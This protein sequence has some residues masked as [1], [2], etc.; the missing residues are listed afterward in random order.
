MN[1]AQR[2][3][4][5]L[6]SIQ[7]PVL[8]FSGG[9]IARN[10]PANP[11][12]FRAD[13]TFHYFFAK[14]EAGS[15]AWFD[16]AN[17]T[18]TLFL[19]ERTVADALWH[20]T[21]ES[22][23]AAK[24]RHEV[25]EVLPV[26]E[27]EAQVARLAGG[28]QVRSLAVA[29]AK[30]TARARAITG[31]ALLFDDDTQAVDPQL[32]QVIAAQRLIKSDEEVEEQRRLVPVTREAH[33]LAMRHSRPGVAEQVLA[34]HVEGAFARAGC[35]PA[36]GTILSVRGEVLHNHGHHHVLANG[37]IV[38]LDAGPESMETGYCNDVTRC[39]P[40]GGFSPE[41]RDVYQ[42]VLDAQLAAIAAVKPGARFRDLHLLAARVLAQGLVSM[43]LLNGTV[44]GLVETGAH[45]MFF[46]HGL[47]H[48]LGLDV[49]DLETFGDQI[50]YPNGRTRSPQFGTQYLRMDMDLAAGMTFTIEPGLYFVPAILHNAEFRARFGDQVRWNRAE[51]FLSM[52]GGRG[53]GG[54]RIED[55]VLCT[56]S[57]SE[58]LTAAIPKSVKE[59]EALAGAL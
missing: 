36:Y 25:T 24:A 2:R 4:R 50:H 3:A 16:P 21:L 26:G 37:D 12:P 43:G 32:A 55:N 15:A 45:A 13:S 30:T 51:P 20:G 59:I 11:Y 18:V 56:P 27:L 34:G 49:H 17:G 58:V 54:I 41:G 23:E 40:V 47:G 1:H 28:R 35:V 38:L 5:F 29:D 6:S 44:D 19:P 31:E 22:F 57:G 39:W 7:T 10:Y 48:Q 8:L 33:E 46:P 14:P 52:N 42:L 9:E 53:F